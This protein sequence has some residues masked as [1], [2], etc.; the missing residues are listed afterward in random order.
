MRYNVKRKRFIFAEI[1]CFCSYMTAELT[2]DEKGHK[3]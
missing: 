1:F 2:N 3:N